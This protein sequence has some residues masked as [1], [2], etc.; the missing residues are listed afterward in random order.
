MYINMDPSDFKRENLVFR[1]VFN[2]SMQLYTKLLGLGA[3][4]VLIYVV[5]SAMIGFFFESITGLSQLSQELT[6]D[7]RNSSDFES[8]WEKSMSFYRDNLWLTVGTRLGTDLIMI[9]SFPLAGGFLLVCREMDKTGSASA[10]TLFEG[11]KPIYWANLIVLAFVYFV[12]SKIGTMLFL[13]PGIYI[14]VAAVLGCPFVMFQRKS[15]LEALK[16]SVNLINRDWFKVFQILLV[17]TLFGWLGYLL[18]GIG[19]IV[20]Y[21]FVFVTV[22]MLYKHIVGFQDDQISKIGNGQ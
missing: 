3:A 1:D 11:F 17:A 19:R 18:C 16:S 10:S 13:I 6:E 14:W 21:P 4:T 20:T 22:Y 5:A 12:L 7:L 15:G 2:E 9:L 8:I